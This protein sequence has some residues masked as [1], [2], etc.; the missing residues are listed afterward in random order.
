MGVDVDEAGS[1]DF[2]KRVDLAPR[3]QRLKLGGQAAGKVFQPRQ[4]RWGRAAMAQRQKGLGRRD[5]AALPDIGGN[6]APRT[7]PGINLHHNPIAPAL[8]PHMQADIEGQA[9][10]AARD[11]IALHH[12]G[13]AGEAM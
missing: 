8:A 1:N 9:G 12:M 7:N 4:D 5:G 13:T 3:K 2:A 10:G 11:D 6:A